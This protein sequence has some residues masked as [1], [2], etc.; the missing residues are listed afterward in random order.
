MTAVKLQAVKAH[1]TGINREKK[2]YKI[3]TCGWYREHF[4]SV[5]YSP[6]KISWTIHSMHAHSPIEQRMIDTNAEKQLS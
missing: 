6:T 5:P 2:F 3:Y 4:T 1:R